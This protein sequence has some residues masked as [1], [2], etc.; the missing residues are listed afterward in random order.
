MPTKPD[1]LHE[2]QARL[3]DAAEELIAQHGVT[4]TSLR[5]ITDLAGVNLALVKYHFGSKDN[6][7][8]AMFE[9][10]LAPVNSAR[11]VRLDALELRYPRGDL[12]LEEVLEA[13]IGPAVEAGLNNGKEGRRLLKML[14]RIF[15]E[16][17]AAMQ[18]MRKEMGPMMKRFD[19]AF[20]RALP[21][22]TTMDMAWRKMASLGVVQHSLLM[23]SMMDE[24]PL[25]LR[26]P[27]KLLK[28]PPKTDM[29]VRQLVAF[30]AAGMR[31]QV[32]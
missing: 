16:P 3:L 2:T 27:M 9:R 29:V 4:G 23:L 14:G 30:C 32:P 26:L 8:A 7:V 13:L 5:Q 28:L 11:I 10:R 25:H 17:A 19:D 24:L 12:P 15:A 20:A 22:L 21:G 18:L 6:M 1:E 31:A